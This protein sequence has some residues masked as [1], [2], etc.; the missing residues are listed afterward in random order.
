M[1]DTMCQ[2]SMVAWIPN[3]QPSKSISSTPNTY[4]NSSD[5]A[6]L[7]SIRDDLFEPQKSPKSSSPAVELEAPVNTLTPIEDSRLAARPPSA[8]SSSSS[9]EEND[10][11]GFPHGAFTCG[12]SSGSDSDHSTSG[13]TYDV[14]RSNAPVCSVR[15]CPE[16]PPKQYRT[17]NTSSTNK[18]NPRL[19]VSLY[20]N[21]GPNS[22]TGATSAYDIKAEAENKLNECPFYYGNLSKT[23]AS[24][25]LKSCCEGTY[26]LRNSSQEN[27]AY[28]LS[29]QTS[30]GTTSVRI[31]F[32]NG[33]YHL[34]TTHDALDVDGFSCVLELVAY[35]A[36]MNNRYV[37]LERCGRKNTPLY[38][39]HPLIKESALH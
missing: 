20:T 16:R 1:L 27:Y 14:P 25:R 18:S 37:F 13:T 36:D 4:Y 2:D 6:P 34:D 35:Y 24:S 15:S 8:C 7:F 38:L 19:M 5:S 32:E 22:Q 30:R 39:N 3:M 21:V 23:G 12:A 33:L 17:K 29:V 31:R 10:V 9:G 26:L 28:C 11:D